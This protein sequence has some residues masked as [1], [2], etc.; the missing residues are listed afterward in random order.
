MLYLHGSSFA[1]YFGYPY[2]SNSGRFVINGGSGGVPTCQ[3][4][5]WQFLNNGSDISDGRW[6]SYEMHYK[7]NSPQIFEFWIDGVLKIS[8]STVNYGSGGVTWIELGSN[9]L[10]VGNSTCQAV[11][12][13][14]MV[15]STT[16]YIG[17]ISGGGG[18]VP[19]YTAPSTPAGLMASAISSSQIN[20]SWTASTDPD[21]AVSG[22]NIYRNGIKVSTSAVNSYSSTGLSPST[23]YSY[24]VDAYDTHG[25]TSTLSSSYSTTTQSTAPSGQTL[26][27]FDGFESLNLNNW[28]DD[29]RAGGETFVTSPVFG[30]SYALQVPTDNAGTYAH[31]FADHPG[32]GG[33][34][35]D[36]VTLEEYLYVPSNAVWPD[37]N[38]SKLWLMNCFESWTA[39][40][41]L[42]AG[43]GKPNAWAPYYITLSINQ[44]GQPF[45]QLTRADGLGGTGELWTNLWQN[46]GSPIAL[47]KGAWNKMIWRMKLNTLGQSNGILQIWVNDVLKANY[48]SINYRGTYSQY[49]W[50]HLIMY[51][52]GNYPQRNLFVRDNIALYSSSQTLTQQPPSAPTNLQIR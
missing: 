49:G 21:D 42:A 22:Y 36:D 30:G 8:D 10:A 26:I 25:N 47:T 45:G 23:T 41:N 31:F 38:A 18:G 11:D 15:I 6:H 28:H 1:G 5:G 50:N 2:I 34:M 52:S 16:G 19:D 4:C 40:Y 46:Q 14:D 13:D 43:Q 32:I 37:A 44:Y 39:G 7:E 33:A 27:L 20:L 17:P 51:I 3:G 29:Y 48:S 9:A 35:V 12:Y 24:M